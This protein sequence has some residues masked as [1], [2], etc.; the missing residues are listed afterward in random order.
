MNSIFNLTLKEL[1]D[2]LVS[3]GFK[4]FNATQV[5]EGIYKKKV[6]SFNEINNISKSLKEYLINN[7]VINDLKVIDV[8]RSDDTDKY[9]LEVEN[10]SVEC[11]LMRHDY[12]TSICIST[13]I[14]CN[15]GC[16]F[17]ESG[18]LKKIRNLSVSEIVLQVISI[19]KLENVRIQN[20]V[21]MGIGEPFDNFD[22]LVKALNI[23]T[24][25]KGFD[26]GSRKI[27]V[28]TC[29]I[30]PKI[31]EFADLDGQVNLAVSLHAPSDDLRNKVMPI[32]KAY[33]LRELMDVLD[34]YI[35]K[36]NRRVTIEYIL[37]DEINDSEE[38]AMKLSKLLKGKLMYVNLI[39]Y[40]ST[41]HTEFSRTSKKKQDKFYDV[42]YKNNI[43]VGIRHEMGKN[44]KGACGQL[45]ASYLEEK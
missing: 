17:C 42:L 21:I 32:N 36:T 40:N 14:G 6:N 1:E 26:L 3:N 37:L 15:M 2:I 12:A 35:A 45:R 27:T 24:C 39:P 5:F 44:I 18:R 31:K 11:V 10:G 28:S 9:L 22:N 8:L 38:C 30:V 23:L 20:V 33:P 4:K 29:G 16:A 41:S 34:Y 19:Q 13:Q 43:Q 7:Y 25:P